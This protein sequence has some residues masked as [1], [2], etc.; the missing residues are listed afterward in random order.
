MED[1]GYM[2]DYGFT[3]EVCA[4]FLSEQPVLY[5]EV[6]REDP[7]ASVFDSLTAGLGELDKK[8][9]NGVSINDVFR[10]MMAGG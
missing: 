5:N 1:I 9:S 6:A 3:E 2:D 8:D 10:Q 4:E 7:S